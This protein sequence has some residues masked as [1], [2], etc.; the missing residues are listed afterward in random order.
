MI[1][2]KHL[3]DMTLLVTLAVL[4]IGAAA[5]AADPAQADDKDMPRVDRHGDSLPPGAVM[6]LGT[7]RFRTTATEFVLTPDGR[8]LYT[9]AGG[10]TIGTWDAKSGRQGPDV[11]LKGGPADGR[12]WFA[13]DA[14]VLAVPDDDGIGLYD[15]T[16]GDCKSVLPI[17]DKT[18][19]TVA[20]FSPDHETLA[21]GE[22]DYRRGEHKAFIRL[23]SCDQGDWSAMKGKGRELPEI[24]SHVSALAFSPDGKRL[25]A[26]IDN[27]SLGCWDIATAKELWQIKH[28]ANSG[29]AVAPDG[30]TLCT[31]TYPVGPL[32]LWDAE[33]GRKLA[34]LDSRHCWTLRLAFSPDSQTLAQGT[35]E[36]VFLWD[37]GKRKLLR[38]LEEAGGRLAFAVDGKSLFTRGPLLERW[39]V[40]T[41]KPLYADTRADGHVGRV[42]AL[43]FAPDG[44]AVVSRAADGRVFLWNL[45]TGKPR[46]VLDNALSDTPLILT[47]DGRLFLPDE[48]AGA[49]AVF[50]TEKWKEI[51]RFRLPQTTDYKTEVTTFQLSTDGRKLLAFGCTPLQPLMKGED[52]NRLTQPLHGWNVETGKEVLAVAIHSNYRRSSSISPDGCF[53]VGGGVPELYNLRSR[54]CRPLVDAPAHLWSHAVFSSDGRFLALPEWDDE[55][56]PQ[57]KGVLVHEV[58]TGRRVT[59]IEAPQRQDGALAFSPDGRL[60]AVVRQDALEVC[61]TA[62]GKRLLHLPARGRLTNWTGQHFAECLNFAPDGRTLATGHTDGTIL[63][64]DV[65]PALAKLSVPKGPVDAGACWTAL[66][67]PEPPTAWEAIERL[68][69]DPA[70]ALRLLRKRLHPVKI[71]KQ[72]LQVCLADL[73]SDVYETREAAT[74]EL[75][76]V[77]E[78][79][80]EELQTAKEK[81]NSEEVRRRLAIVLEVSRAAVPPADVVRDL[82]AVAVLERIGSDDAKELL[83]TLAAGTPGAQL[84][85]EAKGA[86]QRLAAR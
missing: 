68:A 73:D 39:D 42:Q 35:D 49:I 30:K 83:K 25:Y 59:R 61:E 3:S 44:R 84:T 6:R 54:T 1:V 71:E 14:K 41:G 4:G 2:T 58:H 13:P 20:A 28:Q 26:V 56:N 60:L 85:R 72:W 86:L 32:C 43:T 5:P 70:V 78:T 74:R 16:T 22:Y 50:D 57:W 15:P 63:V 24:S 31:D 7:T 29:I 55:R 82:R 34:T 75:K 18:R 48:D 9:A 76:Q 64:W 33:N 40:K 17:N 12:C 66:A 52:L 21:T 47:A 46:Q 67:A 11:H 62:T 51:K 36:G 79:V 81:T 37:V 19:M 80:A 77:A 38:H 65:T 69:S 10:R 8:T 53:V 23:W 45:A 27:L